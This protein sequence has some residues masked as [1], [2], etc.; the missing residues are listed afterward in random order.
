MEF[1]T[2][3]LA[4]SIGCRLLMLKMSFIGGCPV[5][6]QIFMVLLVKSQSGNFE[7]NVKTTSLAKPHAEFKEAGLRHVPALV[8][9]D[10]IF[11]TPG[12]RKTMDKLSFVLYF[13]FILDEILEYIDT[14]YR[15][16]PLAY[17]DPT[18]ED[19]VRDIFSKFCWYIKDVNKDPHQLTQ[20]LAK[21]NAHLN[22]PECRKYKFLT[23]NSPTHLDCQFLPKLHHIRI[24]AAALK[25]YN[26]PKEFVGVWRYLHNAY[27][28]EF[29]SKSCPCDQEIIIHWAD[30]PETPNLDRAKHA[31]LA[32]SPPTYSFEV[33]I[34]L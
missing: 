5:C 29:F 33:P 3:S 9:G 21:L 20:E 26:I 7:F 30:R 22:E 27:Q 16:V 4:A 12:D 23:G 34:E 31:E 18:A 10:E 32:N 19:A 2:V 11:D 15:T 8:K 24:A 28:S 17:F 6:Q 1:A 25:G 13:L 14:V